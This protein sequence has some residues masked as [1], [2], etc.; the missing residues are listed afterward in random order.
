MA[1]TIRNSTP[2]ALGFP[3]PKFLAL[4]AAGINIS[5]HAIKI[6]TLV[7]RGTGFELGV[8]DES[9]L[10]AGV[11]V[12]GTLKRPDEVKRALVELRHRHNL[13]FVRATIP[14][15]N[16]YF[17]STTVPALSSRDIHNALSFQLEEHVPLKSAEAVFDFDVIERDLKKNESVVSVSVLPRTIAEE[18]IKLF[19][20]AGLELLS[21]EV[22]AQAIARA[23]VPA[24]NP[25]ATL[26]VDIGRTRTGIS[27]VSN[28]Y[29]RYTATVEIGGDLLTSSIQRHL[30]ISYEEADVLKQ[31]KGF[32]KTRSDETLYVSLINVLA[33]LR[34]EVTRRISY[35]ETHLGPTTP[36]AKKVDRIVLCGGNA[37][38]PGVREYL[39]MSIGLPVR[40]GSVWTN[41]F[42][43]DD[44]VPSLDWRHS[45]QYA[46]AIGLALS[47]E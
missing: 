17:F 43:F 2:A 44:Y 3:A 28:G 8:A 26:L 33:A 21:L 34:D 10:P 38:V 19:S 40:V 31:E 18:Y 41:A 47:K 1:N 15:E 5:D 11:V 45:Q 36:D 7:T 13:F 39:E 24:D 27:V 25:A 46:A 30:Q 42:S 4:D 6:V 16:V 9:P 14:E 32:T 35:W 29:I 37:T 20:E 23:V 12:A 22:E